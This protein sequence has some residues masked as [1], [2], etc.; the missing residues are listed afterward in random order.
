MASSAPPAIAVENLAKTYKATTA[1]AGIALTFIAIG[2]LFRAYARPIIGLGTL[3]IILVVYFG[4]VRYSEPA[5]V[6][7]TDAGR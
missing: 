2:F 4:R 3:A 5:A 1:V 6:T 7:I